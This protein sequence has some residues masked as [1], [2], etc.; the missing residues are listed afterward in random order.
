MLGDKVHDVHDDDEAKTTKKKKKKTKKPA[1]AQPKT[2]A[3]DPATVTEL[4]L[5]ARVPCL[6]CGVV[7]LE[8]LHKFAI[9]DLVPLTPLWSEA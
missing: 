7:L 4:P 1:T 5:G 8:V 3:F 6:G 2:P 9:L